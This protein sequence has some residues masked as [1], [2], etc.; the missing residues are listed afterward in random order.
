MKAGR[1]SSSTAGANCGDPSTPDRP[2]RSSSRAAP[3][4]G[5]SWSV[6]ITASPPISDNNQGTVPGRWAATARSTSTTWARR[7][8][9]SSITT[10]VLFS[11]STDGGQTF[12][13]FTH[14]ASMVD[15]PSPLPHTSFRNNAFGAM[16]ADQ[17][18][19]GYLYAVWADYR[20]GDADILFSRSTD[21]GT[22]WGA[23]QRVNDDP[24]GQRQGPVLP[25]DRHLARRPG[26]HRLVRPARGPQR[27][28]LQGVLH[29]LAR[30]RRHL[31]AE[32][33]REQ[34]RPPCPAAAA[35]SATIAASPPR[36]AW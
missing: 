33:R 21:N 19:D 17:Q 30:P 14:I 5:L 4:T 16:A 18:M 20:T 7:R 12:P 22:T 6:P 32:H 9:A 34:R 3:T 36:T 31:R 8:R 23:P 2:R 1:T 35:S 15:L 29:R 11:R 10:P 26:A 28:Q 25:L 13:F 27:R 24:V